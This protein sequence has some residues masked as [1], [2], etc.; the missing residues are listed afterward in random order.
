[1]RVSPFYFED[2]RSYFEKYPQVNDVYA[3]A[4]DY[5]HVEGGKNTKAR[6]A[7]QLAPLWPDVRDE[8]EDV[9][10]HEDDGRVDRAVSGVGDPRGVALVCVLTGP[11]SRWRTSRHGEHH[12]RGSVDRRAW[13]THGCATDPTRGLEREH[14]RE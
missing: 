10:G 11:W 14:R 5:P 13:W 12:R 2:I 9:I 3:F 8:D 6:M 4:S 7:E 1:V